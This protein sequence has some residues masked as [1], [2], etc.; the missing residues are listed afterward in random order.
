[1]N[2]QKATNVDKISQVLLY[3]VMF[4]L[5]AFL[6]MGIY[7]FIRGFMDTVMDTRT[8]GCIGI[9]IFFFGMGIVFVLQAGMMKDPDGSFLETFFMSNSDSPEIT[10][11]KSVPKARQL[12]PILQF[13]AVVDV[14][15][16]KKNCEVLICDDAIYFQNLV[17]DLIHISYANIQGLS[18]D[19][20]CLEI[21]CEFDW[22]DDVYEG[23]VTIEVENAL[24]L[25][26]AM[27][28][29]CKYVVIG[30]R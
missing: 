2:K 27:D 5:L 7:F 1:M 20:K 11:G 16:F 22:K 28:E 3:V 18:R 21:V 10:V 13:S 24:R 4:F 30:E 9:G 23:P 26:A 19:K 15:S 6:G 12:K 25:K 8:I 14:D 29:I 17:R